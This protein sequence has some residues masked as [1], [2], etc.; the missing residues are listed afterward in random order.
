MKEVLLT[1][2]KEKGER[3]TDRNYMQTPLMRI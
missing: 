2:K 3:A 1:K